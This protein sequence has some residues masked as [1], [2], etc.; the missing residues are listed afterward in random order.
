MVLFA[1]QALTCGF[2][3]A[4][5][6]L[7][8]T[9]W[10]ETQVTG[11]HRSLQV[12]YVFSTKTDIGRARWWLVWEAPIHNVTKPIEHVGMWSQMTNTKQYIL[13]SKPYCHKNL[14][15]YWFMMRGTHPWCHTSLWPRGHVVKK[16]NMSYSTKLMT[17]NLNRAVTY[18]ENNSPMCQMTLWPRGHMNSR[19]KLKT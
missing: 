16:L 7:F 4:T 13:F 6:M 19:D 17:T 5:K 8:L 12:N 11:Q 1:V 15:G 14:A 18:D 2:E 10:L 9:G 3:S